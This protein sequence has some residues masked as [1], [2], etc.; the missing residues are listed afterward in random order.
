MGGLA[1][2]A[3]AAGLLEFFHPFDITII[4]LAAHF[5]AVAVV[6][7]V[8]SLFGRRPRPVPV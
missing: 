6:V 1:A 8:A 5:V 2:A 7:G 4:D 3:L